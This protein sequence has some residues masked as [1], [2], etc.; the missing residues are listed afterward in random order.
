MGSSA[1]FR[2]S[3]L[4]L[5]GS[6]ILIVAALSC[7]SGSFVDGQYLPATADA[8]Y[9]ARR[10]LDSVFTGQPVIQFDARM[11]VPEGSWITWPWGYDT[12]LAEIVRLFGPF[13]NTA[14]ANRILMRVPVFA[15]PVAIG[16]VTLITRQLGFAPLLAILPIIGFACLPGVYLLFAVGNVDHHFAEL[17]WT[18]ATLSAGVAF[19]GEQ[20]RSLVP[21]C[22]LGMVLGSA[23]A[24][25]NGL[26]ILQIPVAATLALLWLRGAPLPDRRQIVGF[27]ASLLIATL[28]VCLPSETWRRGAFEFYTLSWFHVHIAACTALFALLVGWLSRTKRNVLLVVTLCLCALIPIARSMLMAREFVTGRLES[29]QGVVEVF[30]PYQLHAIYGSAFSTEPLSWLMWL[31]LPMTLL[32]LWWAWSMPGSRRFA[33]IAGVAGLALL[34]MQSRFAVFG[35]VFLLLTPVLMACDLSARWPQ[36][37][38]ATGVALAVLMA[39]A[40]IPSTRTWAQPPTLAGN[41]G[42]PYVR[43]VFPGLHQLCAERPGIVLGDVNAGHWVRYFSD[44][45]SIA[46]VFLLTP[47]HAQKARLNSQLLDLTPE[48]LLASGATVRYVLAQHSVTMTRTGDPNQP[49]APVLAELTPLLQP[50]EATLLTP[51]VALPPRFILRWQATTEAGQVY[52]RLFEIADL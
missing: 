13:E 21:G 3:L 1:A 19:F 29:I 35:I 50:L 17:I 45:S 16:L 5:F 37:R 4:W 51:N 41:L 49:E 10:I 15:A 31:A 42:F 9:H 2:F 40:F 36:W 33:G 48:Q 43:S 28:L 38:K 14:D 25:H 34:Q 7:V 27:S 24:I 32:N 22:M 8:F 12:L 18:L 46:N 6:T 30:S 44:C 23:V 39:I 26:F 20:R 52:A 47:L 11:H